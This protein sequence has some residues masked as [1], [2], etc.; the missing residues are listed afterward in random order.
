M[1]FLNFF[2]LDC[3]IIES[4]CFIQLA[5]DKVTLISQSGY[6]FSMLTQLISYNF[7]NLF[8]VSIVFCRL[9]LLSLCFL[10]HVIKIIQSY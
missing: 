1:C 10:F 8:L 7:F 2:T 9:I 6:R 4:H 3:L 5:F